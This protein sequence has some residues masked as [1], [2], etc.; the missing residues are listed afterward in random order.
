M[1]IIIH[2]GDRQI[3]GNIIEIRSEKTRILF[4]AGLDLKEENNIELPK[5]DGLFDRKGFDA[6]FVSHTH[7]DHLGLVYKIHPEIPVY[8]GE[9]GYGM[10]KASDEYKRSKS[11]VPTGFLEH[12]KTIKISELS[13][14]PFLCDH[15]AY[16]SYMLLVECEGERILYTGDFRGHGRKPFEWTLKELPKYVDVLICEGTTLSREKIDLQ[17]EWDL[18]RMAVNHFKSTEGPVFVLMSSMNIDRIVT[19]YRATKRTGRIFLEDLY[20]AEITSSIGNSIPNPITFND[21]KTFVTRMYPSDHPRRNLFLKYKNRIGVH[22]IKKLKFV[23]CV[24]TSMLNYLKSL[25]K[26]M[27]FEGGLLIY[28]FWSGYR[29]N[30]EMI[31]FLDECEKIGLKVLTLHTSGHADEDTILRLIDTIKPKKVTIVHSEIESRN[32]DFFRG[33]SQ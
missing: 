2:R 20:M 18:E 11:F 24:R 29:K 19:M 23:M 1:D 17:S 30:P 5:V 7:M 14:T 16:D 10:I 9:R 13:V 15:S 26:H 32:L 12:K 27:S 28:S 33:K 22:S 31:E 8:L 6:V 3:G 4:D 25:N 21:V